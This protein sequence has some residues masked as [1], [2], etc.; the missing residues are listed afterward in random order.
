L[1]DEAKR[2]VGRRA[3]DERRDVEILHLSVN[4]RLRRADLQRDRL[5]VAR[6]VDRAGLIDD[7]RAETLE[8]AAQ[9]NEDAPGAFDRSRIEV[10]R[11]SAD[12]NGYGLCDGR[13]R[14]GK[15]GSGNDER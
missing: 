2:H 15:R 7:A 9:R 6:R 11:P 12:V 5:T 4:R 3:D 8:D 14:R 10:E 1:S 13:R